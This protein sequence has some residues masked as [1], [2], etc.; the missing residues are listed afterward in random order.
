M[1]TNLD[2]PLNKST[3]TR[4]NILFTDR[5]VNSFQRVGTQLYF[6]SSLQRRRQVG[7]GKVPTVNEYV[8]SY[9]NFKSGKKWSLDYYLPPP[10]PDGISRELRARLSPRK[11]FELF[12][13]F[14]LSTVGRA[15]QQRNKERRRRRL[16]SHSGAHCS[17]SI[18]DN[19][20]ERFQPNTY[21]QQWVFRGSDKKLHFIRYWVVNLN[22]W[23]GGWVGKYHLY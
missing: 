3:L 20:I 6:N 7:R 2:L 9:Q 23:V 5:L 1:I 10:S 15:H 4:N 17:F 22:Y 19:V 11:R 13:S 8:G 12:S 16:S 18:L 21:L 14:G